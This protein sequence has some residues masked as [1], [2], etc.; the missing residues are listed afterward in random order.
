METTHTV[1]TDVNVADTVWNI[2]TAW[3]TS[4]RWF[5]L[6]IAVIVSL[7]AIGLAIYAI[8]TIKKIHK[9]N[10]D[11]LKD[12]ERDFTAAIAEQRKDFLQ[13]LK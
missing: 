5:Y 12:I 9:E 11:T 3:S 1:T 10:T 13:H 2:L 8:S 7:I 6:A 4:D